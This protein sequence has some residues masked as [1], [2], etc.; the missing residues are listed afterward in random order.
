[1]DAN[2]EGKL[3]T[4]P[5]VRRGLLMIA[6]VVSAFGLALL[7]ISA[8]AKDLKITVHVKAK[9]PAGK[10]LTYHWRSTD[11][12]IIDQN[13]PSTKWTLPAGPGIHFGYVL[14]SNG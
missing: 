4:K 6:A 1:M 12:Q 3:M 9:D 8:T 5:Y 14:V 2:S 10:P 13:P 11:G 7:P